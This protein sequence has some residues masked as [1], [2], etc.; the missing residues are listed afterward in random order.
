MWNR[1]LSS[2]YAHFV[3][4]MALTLG[5][6][7]GLLTEHPGK[8]SMAKFGAAAQ[9]ASSQAVRAELASH[10]NSRDDHAVEIGFDAAA[11]TRQDGR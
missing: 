4:A 6:V 10:T 7:L 3:T 2:P 9:K 8:S 11:A 1:F 5:L